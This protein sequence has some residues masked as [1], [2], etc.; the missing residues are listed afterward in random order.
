MDWDWKKKE[1]AERYN[2]LYD[3]PAEDAERYL[4]LLGLREGDVFV[5]FGCGR[6]DMLALAAAKVRTAVGVDV[7][8][9]Q[10]AL[11]RERLRGIG[12]VE[13]VEASFEGFDAAGR[14]FTK[15]FARKALHHL[16]D[17][18]KAAFFRRLG[19]VFEAGGLFLLEDAVY[20]FDR[21]ELDARMPELLKEL[22]AY[23]G[24]R[25]AAKKDDVL[26][27]LRHEF[28]TGHNAWAAALE[29]GGFQVVERWQ[30]TGF[31]G[32][33]LARRGDG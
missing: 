33:F 10:I 29:A 24:E 17:E 26:H 13:F 27:M 23:F 6:G 5:D 3:L 22:E 25:W 1:S 19:S 32:G 31:L 7:S 8:P 20:S 21:K 14:R 12:N 30:T 18:G 15:G 4:R 11:A 9:Q 28:P 16:D 2:E